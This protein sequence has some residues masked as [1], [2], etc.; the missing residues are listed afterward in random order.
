[1]MPRSALEIV[2]M[3]RPDR[4][5]SSARVQPLSL[6]QLAQA[7]TEVLPGIGV[8]SLFAHACTMREDRHHLVDFP[9]GKIPLSKRKISVNLFPL[10]TFKGKA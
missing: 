1:M 4:S 7:A 6:T 3:T 9:I 2:D 10:G 5:A 8:F